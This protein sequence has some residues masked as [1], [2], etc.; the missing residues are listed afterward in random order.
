MKEIKESIEIGGKTLTIASG[1]LAG[2]ANGAVMVSLGD[3]V[4]FSAATS[5]G[6]DTDRDYF[7]L[8]VD[9]MER[10]Y[11]GGRIKGSRWIKRE[12]KPTDE[13]ILTSR[14]IDR[15]I[16]PLF[17]KAYKKEVQIIT[18]VLSVDLVNGP[19][20]IGCIASSVAI[21]ISDIPFKEPVVTVSVGRKDGKLIAFPTVDELA[22]GD[23]DLTVSV[24]K[25]SVVMIEAGAKEV[26]EETIIEGIEL[27]QKEGK[28]IVES[29][30]KFVKK[31]GAKKQTYVEEK[32]ETDIK[33]RI[34]K[35]VGNKIDLL[36]TSMASTESSFGDYTEL[37]NAVVGEFSDKEK[38]S[39]TTLFEYLFKEKVR[40][41][42]LAGKRPDGRKYNQ[43]RDLYAEVSVLPRTHGSAL[44]ARGQT[45]VLNVATLGSHTF[46]QLLESAEGEESKRYIHHY[47]MPPYATGEVGRVGSPNRREVGHGALA[48]RALLPVIPSEEVFP[49][50]IR[51]VSEVMSSNGSTSMASVCASTL[52]LMDAGVPLT[53]PVSGIAMGLVVESDKKYAILTDI[54]G[55]EDGNGDM[56]FKVAGTKKGVTALQ[57]DVKTLK[58]TIPI[59]KEALKQAKAARDQIM[60]VILKTLAEPRAQVSKFAPKIKVTKI[61]PFKIGELVGPG[62]KTIKGIIARTGADVDVEDDGSV[63]VSAIDEAAMTAA[64][65]EVVRLTREIMPNEIYEGEVKRVENYGVFVEVLPRKEGLVHVSDMSQSF[66]KD[67][68]ALVKIGDK[69]TVRVKEIDNLGRLNLSMVMDPAFDKQKETRDR[70]RSRDGRDFGRDRRDRGMGRDN[71]RFRGRRDDFRDRNRSGG[72]HFPASSIMDQSTKGDFRE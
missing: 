34:Q 31:V 47:S 60:A 72:P 65:E 51:V 40:E 11:A 67:P 59:L 68:S 52:S 25:D 61:D 2:Q 41:M 45:Q 66:V 37:K 64:V 18:M 20:I 6:M 71:S 50:T 16:R 10:L 55:I 39:V 46:E 54:V 63:Y 27:A 57:L 28:K 15:S 36:I 30:E 19:E 13:E 48:E 22:N 8:T 35:L 24:T 62:G 17:P 53:N 9:Y 26:D 49:Y 32:F 69:V 44:F 43:I 58:L 23:L 5:S 56:D 29:I 4:V 1:K 21:C 38:N 3:T 33:K 70:E 42:V 14:L 7:P 12:G